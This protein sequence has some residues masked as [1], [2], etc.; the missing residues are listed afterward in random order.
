MNK[1]YEIVEASSN[2]TL[3]EQESFVILLQKR[4]AEEKR[5]RI[6]K[7][8]MESRKEFESGNKH[9]SSINDIMKEI[10]S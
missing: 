4:I 1:F 6:I 8:V 5:K 3:D 7:E 9:T 2:L 10:L